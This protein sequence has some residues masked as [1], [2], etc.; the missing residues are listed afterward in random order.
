MFGSVTIKVFKTG[1]PSARCGSGLAP[2][3][4]DLDLAQR[5]ITENGRR[6]ARRSRSGSAISAAYYFKPI[7]AMY[8]KEGD[9]IKLEVSR[10]F[11]TN[12]VVLTL[13][14]ILL[15]L[16]PFLLIGLI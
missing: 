13:L 2:G 14:T 1:P 7:I 5:L 16:L 12:I 6:S 3:N 10:V 11:K 4:R 15:G 8:L 9:G